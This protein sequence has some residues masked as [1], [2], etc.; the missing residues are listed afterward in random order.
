MFSSTYSFSR[1]YSLKLNTCNTFNSNLQLG[2][3]NKWQLFI[4]LLNKTFR[5][6]TSCHEACYLYRGVFPRTTGFS[7]NIPNCHFLPVNLLIQGTALFYNHRLPRSQP[8]RVPSKSMNREMRK[9]LI[10]EL[11]YISLKSCLPLF[12]TP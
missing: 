4:C 8:H 7:V 11:G 9:L 3:N 12:V 2:T 1:T 6:P 5:L 10:Y